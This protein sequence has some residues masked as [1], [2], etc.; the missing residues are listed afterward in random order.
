MGSTAPR[1]EF[2]PAVVYAAAMNLRSRLRFQPRARD[3]SAVQSHK[4]RVRH[5][6]LASSEACISLL[7]GLGVA[8]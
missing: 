6:D 5:P 2:L 8:G 3:A 4:R 1:K 7:L